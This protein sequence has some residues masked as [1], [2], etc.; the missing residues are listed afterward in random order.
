MGYY[1]TASGDSSVA[2]GYQNNT[3]GHSSFSTSI[4][5]KLTYQILLLIMVVLLFARAYVGGD[6]RFAIGVYKTNNTKM[7][8]I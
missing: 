4:K 2:M 7:P 6:I 1:N 8:L 3:D 5:I